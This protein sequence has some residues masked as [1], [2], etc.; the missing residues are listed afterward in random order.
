VCRLL[1]KSQVADEADSGHDLGF[2]GAA[3]PNRS[4]RVLWTL[5]VVHGPYQSE[6]LGLVLPGLRSHRGWILP[7]IGIKMESIRMQGFRGTIKKR[8]G[9]LSPR[10]KVS[11]GCPS[12]EILV[13]K[14]LSL[15]GS[16]YPCIVTD[17]LGS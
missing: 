8:Y 6:V 16:S 12:W 7:R 1:T 13:G 10:C 14:R 2:K 3:L 5:Q 9:F 17:P 11:V 4:T 15:D